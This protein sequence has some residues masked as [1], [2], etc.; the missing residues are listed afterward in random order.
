MLERRFERFAVIRMC[1]ALEIMQDPGARELQAT[2]LLFPAD[3]L[4]AFR[5]LIVLRLRHGFLLFQLGFHV[6][7]LPSSGHGYILTQN[8]G[9]NG[10]EV[11]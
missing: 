6:F 9:Q 8:G 4:G 7:T 10:P 5:N 1:G 3:L 11:A 2:A